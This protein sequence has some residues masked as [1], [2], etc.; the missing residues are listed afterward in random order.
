MTFV[1]ELSPT[2]LWKYFDRVL[3]IPR[4]SKNEDQMR[5]FIVSLAD[6][7][8]LQY[9]TDDAGNLVVYKAGTGGHQEAPTT[10]LQS[11]LDMVQEKNADIDFDFSTDAI[12]P[13]REGEYLTAKGTTLGSDNGI[14]VAAMLENLGMRLVSISVCVQ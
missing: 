12:I 1:S 6:K 9:K 3:A 4:A 10:I 8:G 7:L 11:H 13:V 2:P 5:Q 14:G